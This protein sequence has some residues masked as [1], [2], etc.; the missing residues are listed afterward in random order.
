MFSTS[1]IP[2]NTTLEILFPNDYA[3]T[4]VGACASVEWV[5]SPTLTCSYADLKLIVQGGFPVASTVEDF[6]V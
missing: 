2:A 3:S 6:G 5:G 1:T 4:S